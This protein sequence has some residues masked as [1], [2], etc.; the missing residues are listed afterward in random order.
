MPVTPPRTSGAQEKRGVGSALGPE[1]ASSKHLPV[2]AQ[3]GGVATCGWLHRGQV[4]PEPAPQ[5]LPSTGS[6]HVLLLTYLFRVHVKF[7]PAHGY[8]FVPLHVFP[9]TQ[10]AQPSQYSRYQGT[11]K[12]SPV[13]P[14][15]SDAAVTLRAPEGLC[16][17]ARAR[18]ARTTEGHWPSAWPLAHSLLPCQ[19]F[20]FSHDVLN[21]PVIYVSHNAPISSARLNDVCKPT[22]LYDHHNPAWRCFPHPSS[23]C[24]AS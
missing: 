20:C 12:D 13:P 14:R 23:R 6:P 17:K 10:P 16:G 19:R 1:G 2:D 18:S 22:E 3:G 8:L 24:R 21:L 4:E 5:G 15:S 11:S 9:E 7:L